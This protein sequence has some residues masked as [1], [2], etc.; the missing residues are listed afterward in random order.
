MKFDEFGLSE[1]I[2]KGINE[3]GFE[4]ATPVQ[5]ECLPVL[6]NGKQDMVALAQTGTGKTAAFGL[7]LLEMI[8]GKSKFP[9]ALILSPT[10]ELCVQ[11]ASDLE[12]YSKYMTGHNIVAVYGGATKNI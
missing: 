7:P 8:K 12:N 6:L 11:I 10:R 9:Q 3:L 5:Q 2:L 1:E 4:E